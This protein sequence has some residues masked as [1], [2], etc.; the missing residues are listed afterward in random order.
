MGLLSG[1]KFQSSSMAMVATRFD[2]TI[3]YSTRRRTIRIQLAPR[4][5]TFQTLT[6]AR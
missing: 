6:P 3:D 4:P 2:K 5:V 1:L